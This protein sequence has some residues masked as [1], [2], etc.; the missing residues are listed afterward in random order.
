MSILVV[1][2]CADLLLML[3]T[4]VLVPT[5][6]PVRPIVL[7]SEPRAL[8]LEKEL[9]AM[10]R[11]FTMRGRSRLSEAFRVKSPTTPLSARTDKKKFWSMFWGP[12]HK[13]S[14]STWESIRCSIV[15]IRRHLG[16]VHVAY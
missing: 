1:F 5:T 3:T 7:T 13:H 15:S 10:P 4:A 6:R 2:G 12:W 11:T 16:L 8:L 14:Y 9:G